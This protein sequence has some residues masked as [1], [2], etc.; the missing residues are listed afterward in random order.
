MSSC[1][2]IR[3]ERLSAIRDFPCPVLDDE[4]RKEALE[5]GF[6][7]EEM[8]LKDDRYLPISELDLRAVLRDV[9]AVISELKAQDDSTVV[10]GLSLSGINS[11]H[12]LMKCLFQE[13]LGFDVKVVNPI[14]MSRVAGFSPDDLLVQAGLARLIGLGLGFLPREQ[15]LSCHCPE[16]SPSSPLPS[17]AAESMTSVKVQRSTSQIAPLDVEVIQLSP[18]VVTSEDSEESLMNEVIVDVDE[19]VEEKGVV[20]QVEAREE[21]AWPSITAIPDLE[22]KEGLV[23]VEEEVEE[24]GVVEEAEV[25]EEEAWPSITAI[26]DLEVEKVQSKSEKSPAVE[27]SSMSSSLGELRFQDE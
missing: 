13:A 7:A 5:A 11:A 16:I 23:E 21:E 25:R 24:K 6:S 14:L 2:P 22:V 26:P 9:K 3:F 1:G 17:L 4:Q 19:E 10:R 27:D 20:E 8:T 15:L 12:P 18:D